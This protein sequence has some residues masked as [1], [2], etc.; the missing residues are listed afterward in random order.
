M[1][2]VSGDLVKIA[3]CHKRSLCSYIATFCLLILDPSLQLLHHDHTVWHDKRK[4]LT[5]YINCCKDLHLTAKFVMVTSLSLFH[6]LQMLFQLIFC[7]I[8]SSVDTCQHCVL[9]AASP[10]SA[11][12]RKKLE[13][14]DTFYTHQ[15]RTCT[16]VCPVSL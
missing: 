11:G 5:D 1:I 16:K 2:P 6:L 8:C 10:V 15:V 14:L 12:R 9:F 13:C 4:S 7:C 3:L